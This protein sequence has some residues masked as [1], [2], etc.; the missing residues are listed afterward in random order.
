MVFI[1]FGPAPER[2]PPLAEFLQADVP[3]DLTCPISLLLLDDPVRLD[4]DGQ[5]YSRA[6]IQRH[7][8]A[9]RNGAC[10]VWFLFAWPPFDPRHLLS[11]FAPRPQTAT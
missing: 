9:R 10:R 8:V 6:N 1:F 4:A 7:F 2:P 11:S 3:H 5:V